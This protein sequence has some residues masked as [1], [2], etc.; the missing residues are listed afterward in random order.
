MG[1]RFYMLC[2]RETVGSNASFWCHNGNGYHTNIDKAH[3]YTLEEAQRHWNT[4]REID[5]PIC[6]DS[7]D[8]LAVVHVDH[9][10]VPGTTTIEEGCTQYVAFQKERW[11]G[12]DL[13]WLQNGGLPTTD[14]T[15]ANIFTEPNDDSGLAWL[16]FHVADAVK[17]R[18]FP[19][20]L[21]NARRMVQAAG[22]RVPDHI[23]RYRRRKPSTGKVRFNCP[24]CG[25]IHWQYN[26][27]DF[28]GCNDISCDGWRRRY[29]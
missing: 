27:Y 14:F 15:K 11:D 20:A 13:Y 19:I 21:F 29:D 22:L 1:N 17:R 26:P 25:R 24:E 16:P 9:Q 6:A 12:N 4:S 3:V 7:V 18:T 10:Y 8:E 28:E 2:T 23:S 5:Q